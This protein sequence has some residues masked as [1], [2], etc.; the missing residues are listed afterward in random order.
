ML[1]FRRRDTTL[2]QSHLTDQERC[3]HACLFFAF[4]LLI[5]TVVLFYFAATNKGPNDQRLYYYIGGG[6]SLAFLL[7]II[8]CTICYVQRLSSRPLSST[9][10]QRIIS[11]IEYDN[12][13]R[14]YHHS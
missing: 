8:L 14:P 5:L 3:V 1:F 6:I 10:Q 2:H 4:I 12:S 13:R 7:L 9:T 11:D